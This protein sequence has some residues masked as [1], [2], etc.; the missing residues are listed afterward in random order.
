MDFPIKMLY[1]FE[2]WKQ[3]RVNATAI[4]EILNILTFDRMKVFVCEVF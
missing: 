2:E 1:N 4:M 3:E